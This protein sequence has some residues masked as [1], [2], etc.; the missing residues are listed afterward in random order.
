MIALVFGYDKY[1]SYCRGSGHRY[2]RSKDGVR[3]KVRHR[4]G[5]EYATEPC[6]HCAGQGHVS[7]RRSGEW[8]PDLPLTP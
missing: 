2:V 6:Q 1:C 3:R 4:V 8:K 7:L 5:R